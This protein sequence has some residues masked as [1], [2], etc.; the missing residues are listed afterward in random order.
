MQVGGHEGHNFLAMLT[1]G[2]SMLACRLCMRIARDRR[3]GDVLQ[4]GKHGLN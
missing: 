4:D 1:M 2:G 3:K